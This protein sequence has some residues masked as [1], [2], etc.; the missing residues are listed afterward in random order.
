MAW[1][2]PLVDRVGLRQRDAAP[3][4]VEAL[5]HGVEGD[6]EHVPPHLEGERATDALDRH[7]VAAGG[8]EGG[9]VALR[10]VRRLEVGVRRVVG[11]ERLG[12]L[13]VLAERDAALK[14]VLA[15]GLVHQPE[16]SS[17]E[18]SDVEPAPVA[19][20]GVHVGEL[21][22]RRGDVAD[23]VRVDRLGARPS[24]GESELRDAAV[25]R[26]AAGADGVG[27]AF[28]QRVGKGEGDPMLLGVVGSVV[29]RLAVH[30]AIDVPGEIGA[31][32]LAPDRLG[33][34]ADPIGGVVGGRDPI[35]IGFRGGDHV[36]RDLDDRLVP[37][38]LAEPVVDDVAV[39]EVEQD[40]PV[41]ESRD[42]DQFG[43]AGVRGGEAGEGKGGA[44]HWA[45]AGKYSPRVRSSSSSGL[46]YRDTDSG[47][48]EAPWASRQRWRSKGSCGVESGRRGAPRGHHP[49]LAAIEVRCA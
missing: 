4:V 22:G 45:E 30:P 27:L 31:L 48:T 16:T 47:A 18:G 10:D 32:A 15:G 8:A 25:G 17:D 5:R 23:R 20:P 14:G 41:A 6:A 26:E 3:L 36:E 35:G 38:A 12:V 39:L 43:S 44:H 28:S 42:V 34:E 19:H 9:E 13:R 24:G 21:R 40:D 49:R 7:D 11:L 1:R 37:P 2:G 46:P 29:D 33:G